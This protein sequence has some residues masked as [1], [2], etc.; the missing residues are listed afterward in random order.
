MS[1]AGL[2]L[3]GQRSAEVKLKYGSTLKGPAGRSTGEKRRGAGNHENGS[4]TFKE[5]AGSTP[6]PTSQNT[7]GSILCI[8]EN[9]IRCDWKVSD[10]IQAHLQTVWL[11][12]PFARR[13]SL[14]SVKCHN[15]LGK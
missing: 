15:S 7:Q 9:E 12:L 14:L 4:A 13:A 11:R 6:E 2:D 10:V 8:S 3:T 1:S 5:A